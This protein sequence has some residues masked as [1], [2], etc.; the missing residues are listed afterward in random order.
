MEP[1]IERRCFA[2]QELR[3]ESDG[4]KRMIR[5]HAAVFDSLSEEL[6]GFR[7]KIAKGAFS[8]SIK[9]DDVRALW[10]HDPN[11]ILGRNR[12]NTLRMSEDDTGLAVEID[13][14]DT[15][16]GRDLMV[17]IERGDVSQMS[18]GFQTVEDSWTRGTGKEPDIR[19]LIEVRLFDVSPVVYPAYVQ[20]DVDVAKRSHDKWM[21]SNKYIH[22]IPRGRNSLVQAN[23]TMVNI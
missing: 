20:T 17:S 13:M 1:K 15:Q 10:N 2:V 22:A 12:A 19:T 7:E 21:G 23:E 5:G 3:A 4:D 18:F 11:F 14:P 6:W 9:R 16:F 8:E